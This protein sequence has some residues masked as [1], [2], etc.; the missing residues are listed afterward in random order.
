MYEVYAL[1]YLE[2]DTTKCQFFYREASHD[3]LTLHYFVWLILGVARSPSPWTGLPRRAKSRGAAQLR[4]A[5]VDGR[6]RRHQGADVPPISLITHRT[7]TT[8]PA[9]Q[10]FSSQRGVLDPAGEAAF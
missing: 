2:R 10:P 1:K 6:A 3:K 5:G 9:S 7:T 4:H 8:G